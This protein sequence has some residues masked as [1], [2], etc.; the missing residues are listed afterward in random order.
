MKKTVRL[1]MSIIF[2]FASLFV[3]FG[4]A[5]ADDG[6]ELDIP[7]APTQSEASETETETTTQKHGKTS[8][9]HVL[10]TNTTYREKYSRTGQNETEENT[11]DTTEDVGENGTTAPKTGVPRDVNYTTYNSG[12]I[13]SSAKD[14]KFT[15][16]PVPDEPS[17]TDFS[18]LISGISTEKY[19]DYEENN[20]YEDLSDSSENTEPDENEKGINPV[21][22]IAAVVA[23]LALGGAAATVIITKKKS[24]AER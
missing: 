24:E 11:E 13:K 20:Y 12:K 5:Y 4:L 16:E 22:V 15:T 14:G 6:E 2:V 3:I 9:L 1:I 8:A 18:E 17:S 10:S 23:V 19:A 21:F 7:Q